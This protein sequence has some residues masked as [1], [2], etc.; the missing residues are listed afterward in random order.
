MSCGIQYTQS[1][2]V[3]PLTKCT[4]TA[5]TRYFFQQQ[6]LNLRTMCNNNNTLHLAMMDQDPKDLQTAQLIIDELRGKCRYQA[7][8]IMKW[9]KAYA[10]QVCLNTLTICF[11]LNNNFL[12]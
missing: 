2:P 11:V 7:E 4:V 10:I 9:K 5:T 8:H 6:K 12:C 1:P 3:S